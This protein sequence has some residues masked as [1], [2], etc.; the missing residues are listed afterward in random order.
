[1]S[2]KPKDVT[3]KRKKQRTAKKIDSPVAKN[4]NKVNKPKRHKDERE[5]DPDY[6]REWRWSGFIRED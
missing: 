4:M 6:G 5:D 1:M 3:L 2:N